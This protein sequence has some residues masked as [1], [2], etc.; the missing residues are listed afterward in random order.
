MESILAEC[1]YTSFS[2]NNLEEIKTIEIYNIIV[3]AIN[4]NIKIRM[5]IEDNI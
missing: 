4:Y 1:L 3:N 5:Y 2:E